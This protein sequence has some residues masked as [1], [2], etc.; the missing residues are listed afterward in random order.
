MYIA[1]T[2]QSLYKS[3]AID[4]TAL[5]LSMSKKPAKGGTLETVIAFH[6]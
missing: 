2:F 5:V 6:S 3:F 1:T 4:I